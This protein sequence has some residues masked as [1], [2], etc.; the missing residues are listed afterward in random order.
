MISAS[1][2]CLFAV[3]TTG[4]VPAQQAW[5][6]HTIDNTTRG[7]DGVRLAD[8]NSDGWPDIATG[9]E[10]GGS[11]R[12]YIHPG[13]ERASRPWPSVSVGDV[14]SPEDAVM[15]DLDGDGATDV[16]SSCEGTTKTVYV[17]W[18]PPD[19]ADYLRA[20]TWSTTAISTTR[21]GQAWMFALPMDIDGR[22][23]T[24]LVVGSK[25]T[26]G[27][28]GWL[29]AP[30]DARN[31]DQWRYHRL[32]D[33]GWIMSLQSHDMDADGDLDILV[34]DRKG[35]TRGVFWLENP[36]SIPTHDGKAWARRL[37]GGNDREVMFLTR[38]ILNGKR[39]PVV[40]CAVRDR[41]VSLFWTD[42][43]LEIPMPDGCGTGKG[44]SVGDV[45]LDGR[46]DIVFTC[47]NARDELSGIRWLSATPGGTWLDHEISGGS[48]IKFDRVELLDLDGDGDLDVLT[49][50]ERSN[51]GV[52][53]YENPI[54]GG[55]L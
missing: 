22:H 9:W 25:G 48:G 2:L 12:V 4:A 26:S 13:P 42:E 15:V 19:R 17:H 1:L 50:E 20:R 52:V 40:V 41:G 33:A 51:L 54:R 11:V 37:L 3:E 44:V 29:E 43:T 45:D 30:P 21:G 27:A 31:I 39:G 49:C 46:N 24:D 55:G 5:H 6:R 14:K 47:E 23:G 36:G 16:V 35:P 28:I 34:S 53:W 38:G 10:E 18:A 8:V 32:C 7:A